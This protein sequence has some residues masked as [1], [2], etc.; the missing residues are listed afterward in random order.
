MNLASAACCEPIGGPGTGGAPKPST[1]HARCYRAKPTV[2]L[3]LGLLAGRGRRCWFY[4]YLILDVYSRMIAG[5]E[6]H[7]R[8]DADHAEHLVKRTGLAECIYA[9]AATLVLHAD[10]RFALEAN[11]LLAMLHWLGV[12]PSHSRPRRVT[13]A[14]LWNAC[15]AR[16]STGWSS[17]PLALRI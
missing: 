3:G 6:I 2:A 8:D 12:K 11:T 7:D 9:S 16:S 5:F 13:I 15:S 17:R 14:P 4:L 1:H 10:N